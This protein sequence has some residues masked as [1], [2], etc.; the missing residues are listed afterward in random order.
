MEKGKT[1]FAIKW[2]LILDTKKKNE[3]NNKKGMMRGR[4]PLLRGFHI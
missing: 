4:Y 3:K 1:M 2:E